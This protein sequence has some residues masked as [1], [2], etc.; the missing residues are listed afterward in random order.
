MPFVIWR[1]GWQQDVANMRNKLKSF[2]FS[3]SRVS[4]V[5]LDIVRN[6]F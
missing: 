6:F 1:T 2:S 5:A 4:E 3:F